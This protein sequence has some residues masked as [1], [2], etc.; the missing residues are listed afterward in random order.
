MSPPA[1][2]ARFLLTAASI[3]IA[4]ASC[5]PY[6][7][8]YLEDS[9]PHTTQAELIHK[10]GYPQRLKRIKNGDTVWEYDFQGQGSQCASYAITFDPDDHL[11]DWT[12][13]NCGAVPSGSKIENRSTTPSSFRKS[14]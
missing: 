5:G 10:F 4:V 8:E 3:T 6:R 13:R 14:R 11:R 12:R 2:I 7:V 1:P 9:L